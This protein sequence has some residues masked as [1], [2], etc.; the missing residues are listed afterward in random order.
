VANKAQ[1][2][3]KRRLQP[4]AWVQQGELEIKVGMWGHSK[5][6]YHWG[7]PFNTGGF[8]GGA[9]SK[10]KKQSASG[11]GQGPRTHFSEEEPLK[12]GEKQPALS[13]FFKTQSK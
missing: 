11:S 2:G 5:L 6:G 3:G 8:T 1:K 10:N 13:K 12:K 4:L 9:L 7:W